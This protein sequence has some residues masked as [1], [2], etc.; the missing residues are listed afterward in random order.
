MISRHGLLTKVRVK[1]HRINEFH[2]NCETSSLLSQGL[3]RT[4]RFRKDSDEISAGA[5]L[6]PVP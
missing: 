5:G 3:H 6:K 2:K 4:F 1:L